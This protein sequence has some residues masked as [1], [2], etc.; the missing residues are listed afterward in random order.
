MLLRLNSLQELRVVA[1]HGTNDGKTWRRAHVWY[2][3]SHPDYLLC[4]RTS[5][6]DELPF[7]EAVRRS[8]LQ[9]SSL[10]DEEDAAM[11]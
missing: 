2:V 1:L 6:I 8:D 9:S 10:L 4:D 3:R 7:G 11:S 5:T